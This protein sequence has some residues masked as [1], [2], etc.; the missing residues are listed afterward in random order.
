MA[1]FKGKEIV[2]ILQKLGYIQKR[3]TGSHVIMYNLETKKTIPVPVH[4]KDLKSGT[5]RSIIKQTESTEK[6]F[7][8]LK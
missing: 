4:N 6:D 5:L 2:T 1:S 8:R 3:Q 7:L